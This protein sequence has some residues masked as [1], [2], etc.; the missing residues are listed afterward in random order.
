M[1]NWPSVEGPE[2]LKL[3]I[4]LRTVT[5]VFS[6]VALKKGSGS[7][8]GEAALSLSGTKR[9]YPKAQIGRQGL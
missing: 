6:N 5:F 8:L 7:R 4:G 2:N 9:R 3:F 1:K